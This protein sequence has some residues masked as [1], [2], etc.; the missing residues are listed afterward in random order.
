MNKVVIGGFRRLGVILPGFDGVKPKDRSVPTLDVVYD[1]RGITTCRFYEILWE[2]L[3]DLTRGGSLRGPD[4]VYL[5]K[6]CSYD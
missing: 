6:V 4:F 5:V 2:E 1:S 3:P